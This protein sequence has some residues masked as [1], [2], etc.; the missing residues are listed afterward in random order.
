MGFTSILAAKTVQG[1]SFRQN[2][3][4]QEGVGHGTDVVTALP[5]CKHLYH[6][7]GSP[8]AKNTHYIFSG[9]SSLLST[10]VWAPSNLS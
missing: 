9:V 3:Q 8:A 1:K 7:Q 5:R 4:E 6:V 10:T 2:Q